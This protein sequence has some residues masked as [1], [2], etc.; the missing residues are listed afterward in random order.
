MSVLLKEK[1][2]EGEGPTG[3]NGSS[4]SKK[5]LIGT[6][7]GGLVGV[8]VVVGAPLALAAAGFTSMGIAAG[9]FGASMMSSA[10]VANGG[11]IAAGST[12]M[13]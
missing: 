1:D 4:V 8:G 10:A 12:V 5:I 3:D 2:L 11:M 7:V 13:K 9:S 6:A